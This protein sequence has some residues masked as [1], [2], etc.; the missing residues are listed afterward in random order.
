MISTHFTNPQK[1][2]YL[3]IP[4]QYSKIQGNIGKS[5]FSFIKVVNS[6]DKKMQMKAMAFVSSTYIFQAFL[7]LFVKLYLQWLEDPDQ[8]NWK[9]YA[10][11]VPLVLMSLAKPLGTQQGLEYLLGHSIMSSTV[12]RVKFSP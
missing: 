8:E 4:I 3:L 10:Y 11:G 9:G 6:Y 1:R 7:P 2:S 5:K 12:T